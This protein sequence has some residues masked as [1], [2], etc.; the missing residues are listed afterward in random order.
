M[1]RIIVGFRSGLN[2]ANA[3]GS[4]VEQLIS[5]AEWFFPGGLFCFIFDF[6]LLSFCL[7]LLT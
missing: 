4:I 2:S 7:I 6:V 1:N 5:K 3:H